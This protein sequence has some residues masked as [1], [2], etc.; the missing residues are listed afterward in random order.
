MRRVLLIACLFGIVLQ[1][2]RLANIHETY[3]LNDSIMEMKVTKEVVMLLLFFLGL[4]VTGRS[5]NK[6]D[7]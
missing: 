7:E 4:V 3:S 1:F 5:L 6:E 2:W